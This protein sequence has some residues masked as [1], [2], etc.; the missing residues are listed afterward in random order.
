MREKQ[1][2]RATLPL[3][4]GVLL[5][6]IFLSFCVCACLESCKSPFTT[7]C[8]LQLALFEVR[9][10]GYFLRIFSRNIILYLISD[11]FAF[12]NFCSFSKQYYSSNVFSLHRLCFPCCIKCSY[13]PRVPPLMSPR[14]SLAKRA[15]VV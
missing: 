9:V 6:R 8:H 3:L 14:M 11:G 7:R 2:G 10:D 12:F 15:A 13:P 1:K 4:S 5:K